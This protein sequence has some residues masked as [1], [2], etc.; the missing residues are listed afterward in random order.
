MSTFTATAV[1]S[2]PTTIGSIVTSSASATASTMAEAS[3]I[4]QNVA[5][6]VAGHDANIINQTLQITQT[7]DQTFE[8]YKTF[9]N[10]ILQ[11]FINTELVNNVLICDYSS[12]T[13]FKVVP[14]ASN[15]TILL[16][17]FPSDTKD[18]IYCLKII[19]QNESL[20]NVIPNNLIIKNENGVEIRTKLVYN[21]GAK[22]IKSILD[23]TSAPNFCVVQFNIFISPNSFATV[24][25]TPYY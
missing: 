4:A 19:V 17:N 25:I 10:A 22:V 5:N 6:S 16:N 9:Q 21:N 7:S 24:N 1:S 15:F 23:S 11:N 13:I 8:C 3:T 18:V 14:N 12:A 2:A 20:P